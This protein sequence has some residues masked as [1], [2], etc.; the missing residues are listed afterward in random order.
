MSTSA[1]VERAAYLLYLNGYAVPCPSASVSCG[2]GQIPEASFSLAPHPLLQRLGA[3][4]RIE[5]TIFYLDK[6]ITPSAP[7]W[8]LMFEGELLGWS[9][10]NTPMGRKMNFNAIA[11]IAIFRQLQ[12][13]FM[14]ATDVMGHALNPTADVNSASQPGA[15]YPFSLF[16]KGLLYGRNKST[17]EVLPDIEKP[18]EIL[19]NAVR[20]M[21]DRNLSGPKAEGTP[22]AIPLV[23]F[24]ARWARK[25]NFQNRFTALP[26]FEDGKAAAVFPILESVQNDFAMKT[27][28]GGL[29]GAGDQGTMWDVLQQVF[30]TM[31]F[32]LAML[33]TAPAYRVRLAD[34]YIQGLDSEVDISGSEA[35][36]NPMRLM[37]YFVKPQTMFGIPPCCNVVFPSMLK[38]L[39][40][41]E[42]YMAQ[43]TRF[44]VNESMVTGMLKDDSFAAAALT[45]GYPEVVNAALRQKMGGAPDD[46]TKRSKLAGNLLESG[47]NVLVYPEEFYKGPV[48][49]RSPVPSWFTLLMT[50]HAATKKEVPANEVVAV[51]AVAPTQ[52]TNASFSSVSNVPLTSNS[53][54]VAAPAS[55]DVGIQKLFDVYARYEYFRKRYETRGGSASL[56]WNPYIVPG[57]PCFI[58]DQHAAGMD[59]VGYVQNV[60]WSMSTGGLST[61]ISYGYARTVQEFMQTQFEDSKRF[62]FLGAGPAEM[63]PT[64]RDVVQR[65]DKAEEFYRGL[66][67]GRSTFMRGEENKPA[68][69]L[70]HTL[71][72]VVK[73]E[74]VLSVELQTNGS[75]ITAPNL[76]KDAAGNPDFNIVLAPLEHAEEYFHDKDAAAQYVARPICS[77]REYVRFRTGAYP[78][79][80]A[81]VN[82]ELG[83]PYYERLYSLRQGPAATE[84]TAAMTGAAS[85][86]K[87]SSGDSTQATA[88]TGSKS[89][90]PAGF[91]QTRINWDEIIEAYVAALRQLPPLT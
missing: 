40:Y 60:T 62:G 50:K 74:E 12:Y 34:G 58:F 31:Y 68:A 6:V 52:T 32:E 1:S 7:E 26:V 17:E 25:R 30:N 8:R 28:A 82:N 20:G 47:K 88:Y 23:N 44:Y 71:A 14:T 10:T 91:P 73:E 46:P 33:P 16:K 48:V 79:D 64:V 57:F 78:E 4:D 65:P 27:L 69:A 70:L 37:N 35:L 42:N 51:T 53:P 18:F 89:A 21:M 36:K 87:P 86:E 13:Y 45:V 59:I 11:D 24:F 38:S 3:D 84:P 90:V 75:T 39:E 83:A 29:A 54:A 5:V 22:P 43:P 81:V 2:V 9:Y 41:S 55:A 63:L 72:G 66:F 15:F 80:D 56:E 85:A 49:A 61:Q 67:Y 19:F 76:P 77:M